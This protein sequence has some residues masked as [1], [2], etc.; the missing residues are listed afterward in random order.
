MIKT[1][2]QLK[3]L[4]RNLSRKN[5][6]DAQI[7]M[8][9]YMMERFLERIS[10]SEYRDK[11]IL[12]GGMLVAAMV[13]LDAR[14]TMDLDATVKGA[15]VNVEDVENLISAIVTVPID[16][17]VKFQLK[18]ISEI[19]DE[20]E[21]PGIRVSMTTTF[22]GVVTPLKIDISTGDAITPMSAVAGTLNMSEYSVLI[23]DE[24]AY[25]R[26]SGTLDAA[27]AET[28]ENKTTLPTFTNP[29]KVKDELKA[30]KTFQI[31]GTMY[32]TGAVTGNAAGLFAYAQEAEGY[33]GNLIY[34][35]GGSITLEYAD[36]FVKDMTGGQFGDSHLFGSL[37]VVDGAK[38]SDPSTVYIYDFDVAVTN[39][40]AAE[41]EELY[42]F[43]WGSQ[44]AATGE[45]ADAANALSRGAFEITTQ[46][47]IPD[48]MT[49]YIWNAL[50]VGENG[51]L[52]LED[53][54]TVEFT[55]SADTGR[56][57]D[58]ALYVLGKVVDNGEVMAGYEDD[59]KI[60]VYEV[61]KVSEDE[62]TATYTSLK[63]ALNEAVDGEEI[64]LHGQITISEDLTIP[65]NVTVI[66]GADS[67][68]DKKDAITING[69]TLTVNGTLVMSESAGI[70]LKTDGSDKANVI[71]NNI[72][73][74][75]DGTNVAYTDDSDYKIA[76]AYF[77][78]TIGDYESA[79]FITSVAVAGAN[80]TNTSAIAIQGKVSMGDVT[81]T[82]GELG[83]AITTAGEVTAGTVTLVG[84]AVT[85][86]AGGEA[87]DSFTGTVSSA[88]TAG[89]SAVSFSKAKDVVITL[90]PEDDG[91]TITT[92]MAL[93]IT[94][95][96]VLAGTATI[97]AGEVYIDGDVTVGTLSADKKDKAV[98]TVASGATLVVPE[99]AS[100]I[101]VNNAADEPYSG[102][103]IDGTISIAKGTLTIQSKGTGDDAS[104]VNDAQ[105]DINGTM[106]VAGKEQK[107][108]GIL[109]VTG[110]LNV[111]SE[112]DD[113][114]KVIVA[115]MN[116]G[117]KDGATGSVS[118]TISVGDNGYIYAYPGSDMSGAAVD[119]QEDGTSTANTTEFY[120]NGTLYVTAYSFGT[121]TFGQVMSEPVSLTGYEAVSTW[122]PTPEM[123]EGSEIKTGESISEIASAYAEAEPL[124]VRIQVSVGQGM[125]VYID[126]VR[127][128]NA[129][130]LSLS[131]GQHTVSVQVNPGYTG[132]AQILF[133]GVAVT[134]GKLN[135]TADMAKDAP[136][137]DKNSTSAI[138]LS[139]TGEIAVD[140]GSTG[141]DDGMGLTEILLVILVVLIVVM[142]IMVALRLM[143]S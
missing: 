143:R 130:I 101:V 15:N 29:T 75:S 94:A 111:T 70:T 2:R 25:L 32:V 90:V 46:I 141:G 118:G 55:M 106:N 102:L 28:D 54:A 30:N 51:T 71:V 22:D 68:A 26:V 81:F 8:R 117:D 19:M 52:T 60:F 100:I 62:L 93:G 133:D 63:M 43:A 120:I 9:N 103:V 67:E 41:A 23:I 18:S 96:N 97:S 128:G 40:T 16:D 95:Q 122:F 53:G 69:A 83:L 142:A 131:V 76:G 123:T 105:V 87:A 136:A 13:G 27:Y 115:M 4:I 99:E 21:Y 39:A 134:D 138:I 132:T 129:D 24:N 36:D 11:F 73:V 6:A 119:V 112:G 72:I 127:Y 42:V 31:H 109:N 91:E 139:V 114:C 57:S 5:S 80:S 85:F 7:L 74:N 34:V 124:N 126:N 3:D 92:T 121:A 35:D 86:T 49:L 64:Q 33:F 47:S 137:D 44:N 65:A 66:S 107:F 116:V 38:T 59:E 10:L 14:S 88:V 110:A 61:K 89:T 79:D 48:G 58:A 20:A 45:T 82:E 135:V 78:G 140:T 108:A 77:D 37:Y 56:I 84:N 1:A 113:A 50:V 98:L 125:S 104:D 17:G 12:K